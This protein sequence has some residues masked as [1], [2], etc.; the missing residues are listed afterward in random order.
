M[1]RGVALS[2]L[3]PF[4]EVE[5]LRRTVEGHLDT[6]G[7]RITRTLIRLADVRYLAGD[8]G[9]GLPAQFRVGPHVVV[10]VPPSVEHEAGVGQRRE[11]RLVEALVPEAPV[12]PKGGEANLST[13]PFCI[14]LPGAM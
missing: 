4:V 11:Q 9:G 5:E 13:K 1:N 7:P 6:L 3:L 8:L 2:D 12:D 10:V 14:G